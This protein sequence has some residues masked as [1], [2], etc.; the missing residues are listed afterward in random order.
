MIEG[1]KYS[2]AHLRSF[3]MFMH[4]AAKSEMPEFKAVV[5][6]VFDCHVVTERAAASDGGPVLW[7]DTGGKARRFD[8]TRYQYSLG[9][10]DLIS[11]LPSGR[12]KCYVAGHRNYM[13]WQPAGAAPGHAH[14]QVYFDLY[15]PVLQPQ[16]EVPLLLLYV[17]SAYLKDE[18]F[19]KQRERFKAF[20]AI[21]AEAAGVAPPKPK[22]VRSK[23][24]KPP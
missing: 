18:P 5:R 7:R 6:V 23:R 22:G 2:F 24:Q 4:K 9:L 21:C 20:G 12:I 17:Q 10:P 11:G 3:D 16:G 13:V 15:K 14:Y 8:F 19:A 1:V